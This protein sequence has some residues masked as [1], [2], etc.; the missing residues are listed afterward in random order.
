V[1]RVLMMLEK[2]V[3]KEEKVVKVASKVPATIAARPDI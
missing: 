1:A 2:V 3:E